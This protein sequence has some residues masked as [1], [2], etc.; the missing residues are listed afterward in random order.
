MS[1]PWRA[2]GVCVA[3]LLAT[4]ASGCRQLQ[5]T[6][7]PDLCPAEERLTPEEV[8]RCWE[9]HEATLTTEHRLDDPTG[10]GRLRDTALPIAGRRLHHAVALDY[11]GSMYGGYDDEEPGK[12]PC[13]W[14][15]GADG[16]HVRNGPYYWETAEF[17]Q[18]LGDGPLGALTGAELVYPVAFNRFVTVLGADGS[19]STFDGATRSFPVPLPSPVRGRDAVL[20][21]LT[22]TG[23]GRLP[24]NPAKA[25]FG[26]P[27]QTHL[28]EVLEAA[29]ALFE[30]FDERD[31]ILWVVTDNIIEQAPAD[32]GEV[33]RDLRYNQQFYETLKNDP[34]WQVIHAWPIHR[35]SWMCGSTLMVYGLYYSSRQR[36]GEGE[37]GELCHGAEAQLA[38]ELQIEAFRHY[39]HAASPSPGRPFKLKPHDIE[40]VKLSF[41]GQV[42]CDPVKVGMRGECRAQ[43]EVV[44]LLDHRQIEEAEIVLVNGRC[45]PWGL[46]AGRLW[47]VR[48]AAPFCAGTITR[49][50]KL[51]H[52]IQPGRPEKL[53]IRFESPPVETVRTT[54]ADHW[55][56][57][58]FG[59]FLMFGRMD[60]GIRDLKTS[61]V[62]EK[63]ALQN[64]YGVKDLPSLFSNPST[65]NLQ[66][67]ICLP[68]SVHN[69]SFFASFLLVA[70]IAAAVLLVVIVLWLL[71]SSFR[72]ILIDGVD[73]GRFRLRRIGSRDLKLQGKT[74]GRVKL[75]W[76]GSPALR[77]V[78]GFRI[79]KQ[80]N[81]WIGEDLAT[82]EKVT[83]EILLKN[84]SKP[85]RP[86]GDGT[87]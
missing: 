5:V 28:N 23:T 29:S 3:L 7:A 13:G 17:A 32:A 42:Q 71:K 74:I 62:I 31:G 9:K 47:P 68:L 36:I 50:L 86:G 16:H 6:G 75:S 81:H 30:S 55:E 10:G 60:V 76:S 78:A 80:G 26:D 18:F 27:R 38:H 44:N 33:V 35:A 87:F 45:D 39:A 61:L 14:H 53:A 67:S 41:V 11:S 48:I 40:V 66:T 4:L 84:K 52:A 56:S 54:F 70:L 79:R 64:V 2:G 34:R 46:R 15:I 83:I 19:Y 57:S 20:A 51:P 63:E 59:R 73:Q 58:N 82:G 37:Y 69:P 22:A 21:A 72:N 49:T 1:L 24:A 25:P 65:D 8:L 85:S 12:A 77:G 43:I